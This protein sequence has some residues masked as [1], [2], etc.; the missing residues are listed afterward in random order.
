[1]LFRSLSK[2]EKTLANPECRISEQEFETIANNVQTLN[3]ANADEKRLDKISSHLD[4]HKESIAREKVND[5]S[6]RQVNREGLTSARA[7]QPAKA[8]EKFREAINLM[9]QNPD[10][11][12]NAAQ[13]ILTQQSMLNDP[14]IVDE[15]RRYLDSMSLQH[16]GTRWRLFR[17]LKEMLPDD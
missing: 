15:A 10:Y 17:K 13:I 8:L 5:K 9:P 4:G 11:K 2:L 12:L 3:S 16:T 14:A 6:A 1:M 7:N